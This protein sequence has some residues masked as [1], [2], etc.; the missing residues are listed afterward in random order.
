MNKEKHATEISSTRLASGRAIS[1][2][3]SHL[4]AQAHQ[5]TMFRLV[6]AQRQLNCYYLIANLIATTSLL[7]ALV[8]S[9]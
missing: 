9:Y 7:V 8:T 4:V 3:F 5:K 1:K 6:C 2:V